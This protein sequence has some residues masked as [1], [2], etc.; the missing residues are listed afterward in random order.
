MFEITGDDIALLGDAD[1]RTLVGLLCEAELRRAG[2]PVSAITWGGDQNAKDGGLDV[3]VELPPA[4]PVPDFIPR[5][6]TGFQVKKPDMPRAAVL[7][8]MKPKGIVRPILLDL[9]AA[10][11]AYVIISSTGSTSD[12]ALDRRREAM[13]DAIEGSTAENKLTLDFYDRTR[14]A[15]WVRGHAGLVLW[16]RTHIGKAVPG[17][18]AFGSW[19][20]APPGTDG[21]YLADNQTRIRTDAKD[22]GDGVSAIE[23][24]ERIRQVLAQP[25][26]VVRLVGLSGVGKT[27]LAE[28][29]FDANIGQGALDPSLAIYTNEADG[30]SP[31]PVGLA[32]DL[33]AEQT[34][35]ILVVDNCSSAL[36]R[37][38]SEVVRGTG[39]TLS[40]ITIE[41]DIRDDQPEGTDV[42]VLDTSSPEVIEKL[43]ARR[44]PDLSETNVHTIAAFSGGNARV[45]L[46]LASRIKKT[47]SIAGLTDE[48][49]FTRLFQQ[50]NEPDPVLLKAAQACSLL[51]SFEGEK[52]DEDEAELA[53]LG[54]LVGK[55][56]EELFD[57]VAELR[58]R[59]L[60]QARA[61]WRAVL[62]HAIANRL[63]KMALQRV[64]AAKIQSLLV[65]QASERVRRSFSRRLGYLHDSNEAKS[66]VEGW[67]APTGRLS[68]LLNLDETDRAMLTNIAPVAPEALLAALV[69][70]LSMADSATLQRCG[71]FVRLLRSLA[72]DA[73]SFEAALGLLVRLAMVQGDREDLGSAS[74]VIE[75]LFT[76]YLS[77]TQ[78]PVDMRVKVAEALLHSDEPEV[79]ALGLKAL[80]ALMKTHHFSSSHGFEFGARPRDYGYHPRTYGD[81]RA[82]FDS[83]L[84]LA[85]RI[86]LSDSPVSEEARKSIARAFRGLWV[87]IGQADELERIARAI[88][89]RSFWRE[90][91]IAAREARFFEGK[92]MDS[93]LKE[94][95]IALEDFLRPKDVCSQVRGLVIG[96]RNGAFDLDD[97]E[98]NGEYEDEPEDAYVARA[99]RTATK[100]RDLGHDV[101]VDQGALK[102]LLPELMGA[103]SE[104]FAFGQALGEGA[105]HPAEMWRSLTEQSAASD[106]PGLSLLGGFLVGLQRHDR[107][108]VDDLL[109]AAVTD[110][111]L[112]AHFPELQSRVSIDDR[113]VERLHR[114][115][116]LGIAAITAFYSLAYGR[117]FEGIPD[118]DFRD[119]VLAIAAKTDGPRVAI[120][121]VGMRVFADKSDGRES[122]PEIREAGRALLGDYPFPTR[123]GREVQEDHRLAAVAAY[124][125]VG[126]EG[127]A[128]ARALC[129]KLIDAAADHHIQAYEYGELIKSL[130]KTQPLAILDELFAGDAELRERS[131]AVLRNLLIMD[132]P[133][134]DV[135]PD[136]VILTWC[137]RDA[138]VRYPLGTEVVTLFK[139]PKDGEPHE[140][141]PLAAKLLAKAPDQAVT[142]AAIVRRLRPWTWSGSLATKLEGRLA[143]LGALPGIDAPALAGPM[144]AARA[145]LQAWIDEERLREKNEDRLRNNRF[146]D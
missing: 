32:S 41:Y 144:A 137:D 88:G 30:P 36:H 47:E 62:P 84:G 12:S 7:E 21:S 4:S 135:V 52:T 44:Y 131:K 120:E 6:L 53:V 38:L 70:A 142:L 133:V 105:V 19:S 80:D 69:A 35:A 121:I 113:G 10:S 15:T 11:G 103:S 66:I 72:Y 13:A 40:V 59:D 63:A 17:W 34:R 87:T 95:L 61:E 1:L 82:W 42:F 108:I 65:E 92:G 123:N 106:R 56:A 14:V 57:A 124:S 9:A 16:V 18:Q 112:A 86:A 104:I 91:W 139:R 55:T 77:G 3:R 23:G 39:S 97:S 71:H 109:D 78:A 85:G 136:E 117:S 5:P 141:T 90:G 143:L 64:P 114:A 96:G 89:E 93:A 130:L 111:I 140:W 145:G 119:L 132:K 99:A 46:A 83:A 25:G 138:A 28:A 116:E 43:V 51:Y 68:D 58:D 37:R 26:H 48:E 54:N 79:R 31:P 126:L 115:L 129:R 122:S 29:L 98:D 27:R 24:I 94:R 75:S 76:I 73:A 125:L 81:V 67:L 22:D 100:I 8:E 33:I 102:E 128:T 127:V 2:L 45:A 60:V 49:L 101:A 20:Y 118:P 134:F 107:Q 74:S 146:E 50:R 110:P